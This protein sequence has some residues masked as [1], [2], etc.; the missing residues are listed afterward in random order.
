MQYIRIKQHYVM[1]G[2]SGIPT[3]CI[4]IRAPSA[5]GCGAVTS[6]TEKFTQSPNAW[7]L[8]SDANALKSKVENKIVH[9]SHILWNCY[10]VWH[11]IFAGVYFCKSA[12][13]FILRELIFAIVEDLFFLLGTNFCHL[14]E[15]PL[16]YLLQT[17][18]VG[19]TVSYGPRFFPHRFKA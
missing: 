9:N 3:G 7:L 10:A 12:I 13:F 2:C 15:V 4:G 14:H 11:E 16:K 17:E 6:L 18:F 5:W 8:K 1:F 19:R